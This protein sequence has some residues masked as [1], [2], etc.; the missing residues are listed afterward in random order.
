MSRTP[1]PDR[2]VDPEDLPDRPQ[3]EQIAEA[4]LDLVRDADESASPQ[5]VL[6]ATQFQALV[7]WIRQENQYVFLRVSAVDRYTHDSVSSL[8][9]VHGQQY[10]DLY[11]RIDDFLVYLLP[12][13]L[14][15]VCRSWLERILHECNRD[16]LALKFDLIGVGEKDRVQP[17]HLARSGHGP[18]DTVVLRPTSSS[19]QIT[20]SPITKNPITLADALY[21][22]LIR[23]PVL[24]RLPEGYQRTV[25][26][27]TYRW[28]LD[29]LARRGLIHRSVA[30]RKLGSIPALKVA[31]LLL[32]LNHRLV[33]RLRTPV[34][35]EQLQRDTSW[36]DLPVDRAVQMLLSDSESEHAAAQM[37]LLQIVL[38]IVADTWVPSFSR[39]KPF[40]WLRQTG[41]AATI[42]VE[43]PAV[44]GL[45]WH[46]LEAI[47]DVPA[48]YHDTQQ[49][50]RITKQD[51]ETGLAVSVDA[52]SNVISERAGAMTRPAVRF[53]VASRNWTFLGMVGLHYL[54]D[55]VGVGLHLVVYLVPVVADHVVVLSAAQ[56]RRG[57][58]M[59]V[60]AELYRLVDAGTPD[61]GSQYRYESPTSRIYAAHRHFFA[62]RADPY[63]HLPNQDGSPPAARLVL[64]ALGTRSCIVRAD[65]QHALAGSVH[66]I[67]LPLHT[68]RNWSRCAI[69]VPLG[70]DPHQLTVIRF[71]QVQTLVAALAVAGI[72]SVQAPHARQLGRHW[73][74]ECE[75]LLW[76][77][78]HGRIR[79][80]LDVLALRWLKTAIKFGLTS[81]YGAALI[82]QYPYIARVFSLREFLALRF[83]MPVPPVES[84]ADVDI[85]L[86]YQSA[87]PVIRRVDRC[88]PADRYGAALVPRY[89]IVE[90]AILYRPDYYVELA[91]RAVAPILSDPDSLR[92]LREMMDVWSS[93][94]PS[95]AK[96]LESERLPQRLA[97]T[98]DDLK[99]AGGGQI[100]DDLANALSELSRF[101]EVY[102]RRTRKFNL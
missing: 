58:T 71:H 13:H 48:P 35:P 70:E 17:L 32:Q 83:S 21:L 4:L 1:R 2:V 16:R 56:V 7:D 3:P 24:L 98:P 18:P 41:D 77:I 14:Q 72:A 69:R 79:C 49:R 47:R 97:L 27:S 65:L 54:Q 25:S 50:R 46:R 80:V 89:S 22:L 92:W 100:N 90:E 11:G 19:Y 95:D 60:S 78:L 102:S 88:I 51:L 26:A 10:L 53:A 23:D 91:K 57:N 39:H 6:V 93:H 28:I 31:L 42:R 99:W 40:F 44:S 94:L 62:R 85:R 84:Y 5:V 8:P 73:V 86:V 45:E 66:R 81:A 43:L 20:A 68:R 15:P 29:E 55:E 74:T 101:P 33:R 63:R 38:G 34:Q 52:K 82:R 61:R 67:C 87:L 59:D 12:L 36:F 75:R 76:R 96:Q 37:L 9:A 64:H 30:A